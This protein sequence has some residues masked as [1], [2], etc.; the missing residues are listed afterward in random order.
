[1]HRRGKCYEH[2]ANLGVELSFELLES[3]VCLF[4]LLVVGDVDVDLGNADVGVCSVL[5]DV[6]LESRVLG[7]GVGLEVD[8]LLSI[9]DFSSVDAELM[10][11]VLYYRV[12][13]DDALSWSV[14]T[15]Q[16]RIVV[17]FED[18]ALERFDDFRHGE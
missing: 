2:L 10:L 1:V 9:F 17:S 5:A 14:D 3:L 16:L 4:F 18:P 15:E 7:L 6:L 11:R 13:W 8:V 12:G